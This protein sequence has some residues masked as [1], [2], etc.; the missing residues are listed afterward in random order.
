MHEA[1]VPSRTPGGRP[2]AGTRIPAGERA[3]L[4]IAVRIAR[5]GLVHPTVA[6]AP[7]YMGELDLVFIPI[8]GMP[9]L[10]SALVWRRP[11]RALKLRAFIR[12]A[13]DVLQDSGGLRRAAR[14]TAGGRWRSPEGFASLFRAGGSSCAPGW[15]SPVP[16]STAES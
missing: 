10:R 2:T 13:S 11:A 12:L 6:S 16:R 9:P 3:V 14:R 5:G 4:D 7:S 1:V 8:T 15:R